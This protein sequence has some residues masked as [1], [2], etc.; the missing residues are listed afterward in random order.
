MALT[1]LKKALQGDLRDNINAILLVVFLIYLNNEQ[2]C[3]DLVTGKLLKKWY[4][5]IKTKIQE[6]K[7]R[8]GV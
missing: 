3:K 6:R 1:E 7:A 2:T 4:Q 5:L 8:K